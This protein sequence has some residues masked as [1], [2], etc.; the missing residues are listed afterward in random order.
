MI[1]QV[2]LRAVLAHP[3]L[4]TTENVRLIGF[5]E[6]EK[7]VVKVYTSEAD[8]LRGGAAKSLVITPA[9][10]GAVDLNRTYVL[11]EGVLDA[12]GTVTNVQRFERWSDP[13][14]KKPVAPSPVDPALPPRALA[15][16]GRLLEQPEAFDGRSIEVVG[17]A[18][19]TFE[20]TALFISE[21]AYRNALTK[22]A[23]WLTRGPDPK[24]HQTYIRVRGQFDAKDRGRMGMFSGALA[25]IESVERL[26]PPNSP[27]F[28]LVPRDMAGATESLLATAQNDPAVIVKVDDVTRLFFAGTQDMALK[29]PEGEG[30]AEMQLL[31]SGLFYVDTGGHRGSVLHLG[32]YVRAMLASC[33]MAAPDG[34]QL[35]PEVHAR[36]RSLLELDPPK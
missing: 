36:L 16:V 14:T 10:S 1:H 21:E 31:G 32:R 26:S 12:A 8:A 33:T 29:A 11:V 25:K 13:K 9:P 24:V 15:S 34:A 19:S 30:L 35:D 18:S 7:G 20:S 5:A 4:Y 28:A 2:S 27:D 22:D 3:D 17:F 23:I 6:A